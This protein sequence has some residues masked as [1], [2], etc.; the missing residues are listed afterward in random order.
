MS[1]DRKAAYEALERAIQAVLVFDGDEDPD[2]PLVLTDYVVL[3][4]R[5]GWAGDHSYS[6]IAW[7]FRDG[8]MPWYRIIGVVRAGL[9]RLEHQLAIA[10]D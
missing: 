5:Q 8:D 6:S 4:A 1:P 2:Q 10:D 7:L 9:I 3:A